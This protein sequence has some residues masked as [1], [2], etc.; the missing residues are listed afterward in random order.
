M[1]KIIKKSMFIITIA[2]AL[3]SSQLKAHCQIPCGIYDNHARVQSMFEDSA[4]IKK[5][6]NLI[7]ELAAKTDAQ[8]QNQLVRWVMNKEKHSQNIINTIS[9]YFLTQRIKPN[10]E[11]YTERLI[12]H[13]K[14]IIAAMKAKQNVDNKY[15][16]DLQN[17]I[18]AMATYYP[19]HKHE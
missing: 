8:S 17:S 16:K 13:H 7:L 15:V 14:V 4:T 10:Q 19:E 5:S 3:I 12:K 11:E 2:T 6:T 1:I 9:S 18:E